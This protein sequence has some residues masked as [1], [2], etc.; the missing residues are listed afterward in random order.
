[1]SQ[2]FA[3][4]IGP[5]NQNENFYMG[6][7][8]GESNLILKY[9]FF[10]DSIFYNFEFITVGNPIAILS[11][12][13][14]IDEKNASN[15]V[16]IKLRDT[17]NNVYIQDINK[18]GFVHNPTSDNIIKSNIGDIQFW[19]YPTLFLSNIQYTFQ[20]SKSDTT[21]Q[22]YIIPQNIYYN[23]NGFCTKPK[24]P[25][26]TIWI[27]NTHPDGSSQSFYWTNSNDCT[28]DVPYEYCPS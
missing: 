25:S 15:P 2:Q 28:I 24:D 7:L 8:Y 13:Y 11:A 4:I 14:Y 6:K 16:Y 19:S 3:K 9:V 20:N 10:G 21:I 23:I 26:Y 22:A 18:G 1:M 27:N 17:I 12:E 5:I